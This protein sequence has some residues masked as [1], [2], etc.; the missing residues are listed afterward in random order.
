MNHCRVGIKQRFSAH[1]FP[2][3]R[4]HIHLGDISRGQLH[5]VCR[6]VFCFSGIT[7]FERLQKL[8][9]LMPFTDM[10]WLPVPIIPRTASVGVGGGGCHWPGCWGCD[11]D[12]V[13]VV[14]TGAVQGIT[15]L[16]LQWWV[17]SGGSGVDGKGGMGARRWAGMRASQRMRRCSRLVMMTGGV[18]AF[19]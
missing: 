19:F 12:W 15:M 11:L 3:D 1:S 17:G 6:A 16:N 5:Q 8:P 7:G 14:G 4:L 2:R 18:L 9:V 10:L 13:G